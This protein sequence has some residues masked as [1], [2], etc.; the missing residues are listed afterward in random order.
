M[1]L[2]CFNVNTTS[3][4]FNLE[5]SYFTQFFGEPLEI[6][7]SIN[8]KKTDNIIRLSLLNNSIEHITPEL[9]SLIRNKLRL[10]KFSDAED[11]LDDETIQK[12]TQVAKEQIDYLMDS[13]NISQ[14]VLNEYMN[15]LPKD[16]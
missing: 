14:N 10:L 2:Q 6:L 7:R 3:E 9:I 12:N 1:L 11:L 8:S 5:E 15:Y 13:L 4:L 16:L